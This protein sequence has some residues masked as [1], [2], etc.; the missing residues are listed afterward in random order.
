MVVN[1][2]FNTSKGMIIKKKTHY[3]HFETK[4]NLPF[5]NCLISADA[6]ELVKRLT[7]S[8]A[9]C[10]SSFLMFASMPHWNHTENRNHIR[11][12][13]VHVHAI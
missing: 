1:I 3:G 13:E 12:Q 10:S 6:L 7:T 9:V 8:S 11:I 4:T 5:N 2:P